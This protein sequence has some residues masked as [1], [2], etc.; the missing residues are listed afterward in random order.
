MG[1]NVIELYEH[2]KTAASKMKNGSIL[3]GGVGTGKT[4]TGLYY[5]KNNYSHKPLY[6]ITTPKKRDEGDWIEEAEMLGVEITKVDSWNSVKNYKAITNAFFI[7]DE[8]RAIG[9][10]EWAKSFISIAKKNHWIM[11]S[12]TPGDSWIDLMPAFI[13]H[14]FYQNKSDFV[15]QHVEYDNYVKFPKIKRYHNQGKL[16]RLRKSIYVGMPVVK[17]TL[18][19]RTYIETDY[20]Y[21]LYR[22]TVELRW[23]Y[24]TNQPIVNAPELLQLVRRITGTSDGRIH[25]AA[26]QMIHHSKLI[27]F[28][29]YNY[30]LDILVDLCEFLNLNCAQ[31]NGKL[32]EPIPDTDKWIYLVQYTAGAEGWNCVETDT[33]MF[34]SPNY[35]YKITEQAEGRIDRLNTKFTD[36]KYIYLTSKADIDKSVLRAIMNK[37]QFNAS[38]WTRKAW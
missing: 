30:E 10:G 31:W 37:K 38:A 12:A 25:E 21:E 5:Y 29:N 15:E 14:G 35:S 11:L 8:Q 27:I 24:L 3:V 32:H 26:W 16:Q 2:Q 22:D 17:H 4:L 18:R 20:D 1:S 6:V 13:A 28:Y 36:L 7:F 33:I 23:N 34:Y 19:H 9:Y